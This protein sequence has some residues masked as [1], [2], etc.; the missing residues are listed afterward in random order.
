MSG[1]FFNDFPYTDFHELN[2]SWLLKKVIELN[3]TVKN[4]INLET[5]KYANPI[6]WNIATQYEKNTVVVD[7][8]T[9]TAYIS[10]APVPS[11][12]ALSNPDYW[13]VIF[14]LDIA[15]ANN[16]IT[17][18][19]DGN[20][21]LSTFASDTG[22]W[23]LWNGTLY[24]VTQPISISTAY[25][26]GYN[27]DRYTV[28]LFVKDYV[29]ALDTSIGNINTA[30]GNINIAIG[31]IT[32][33]VQSLEG[34]TDYIVNPK[35]Y[36]AVGDG[37]TDDTDALNQMFTDASAN[38]YTVDLQNLN[39]G[40]SDTV[41]VLACETIKNSAVISALATFDTNNYMVQLSDSTTQTG[42]VDA[43][44]ANRYININVDGK[45]IAHFGVKT[46]NVNQARVDI[47]ATDLLDIGVNVCYSLEN[48]YNIIAKNEHCVG[49]YGLYTDDGDNYYENVYTCNFITGV[50][51]KGYNTYNLVHIWNSHIIQTYNNTDNYPNTVAFECDSVCDV[52]ALYAD[53]VH[54]GVKSTITGIRALI[55]IGS[56]WHYNNNGQVNP[57]DYSVGGVVTDFHTCFDMQGSARAAIDA[58]STI[59]D[60]YY[61]MLYIATDFEKI[62]IPD[63]GYG[64]SNFFSSSTFSNSDNSF[65]INNSTHPAYSMIPDELQTN[66]ASNVEITR[67]S[68]SLYAKA[69]A[70]IWMCSWWGNKTKL[71]FSIGKPTS[72]YSWKEISTV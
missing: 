29:D 59:R 71:W 66:N 25:V 34:K 52:Y 41:H 56:Y 45:S 61:P 70:D 40:I 30:I 68:S 21:V 22:D 9:G 12:V 54:T 1:F 28:E 10:V 42:F 38:G 46:N 7:P 16:N 13:T 33:D 26:P 50:Y 67:V 43:E 18:R 44:D 62:S 64:L 6:Q 72:K 58:V 55:H 36:G 8:Q 5:I 63:E 11:G 31:N 48:I 17:L 37:V 15:Q 60:Y 27:I 14:D 23:L 20:N 57:S 51:N 53:T 3:E 32:T 4:F 24:R 49:N 65:Y 39:Y 35:M 47:Q 69:G 19:D 2:L